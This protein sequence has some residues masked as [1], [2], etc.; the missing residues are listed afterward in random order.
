VF[1][2]GFPRVAHLINGTNAIG[3]I[4]N[5][6]TQQI[7]QIIYNIN[8][9]GGAYIEGNVQAGGNFIGRDLAD[10]EKKELDP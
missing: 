4:N 6:A 8:T 3:F 9:G 5:S 7:S 2:S 1:G 10:G